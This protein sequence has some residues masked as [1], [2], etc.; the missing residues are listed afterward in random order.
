MLIKTKFLGD[1]EIED[2]DILN[3][4]YG[5]PG[6]QELKE[7]ILFSVEGNDYM[8]YMQSIEDEKICF[9]TIS[10]AAIVGEYNVNISDDTVQALEV[11]DEND[12]Q[13]LAIMN[14]PEN[15][16]EMTAN[17]KAPII[18]NVRNRKA[19]QELL[20]DDRYEIK[21]KVYKEA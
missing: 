18:V 1:K 9:V 16:K 7:F 14:I 19:A 12:V 4:E 5:L 13:L 17:L 8:F 10:P 21:H 3:F 2:K 11:E 6:F 15:I 20:S